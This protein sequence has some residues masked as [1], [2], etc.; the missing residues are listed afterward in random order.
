MIEGT[1]SYNIAKAYINRYVELNNYYNI[2]MP[3]FQEINIL[4]YTFCINKHNLSRWL[5]TKAQNKIYTEKVG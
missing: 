4:V 2:N 5:M 3:T 1:I